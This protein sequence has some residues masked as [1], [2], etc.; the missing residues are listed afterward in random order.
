VSDKIPIDHH[1]LTHVLQ[2]INALMQRNQMI[3]MSATEAQQTPMDDIPVL[4]EVYEGEA[5]KLE[6]VNL[7]NFPTLN[8]LA[9]ELLAENQPLTEALAAR[10]L[11]EV[12]PLILK[13][14]KVAVLEES[15]KAEK[16]LTSKLEQEILTLLHQRLTTSLS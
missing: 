15:V 13:A 9:S 14:V 2:R 10:F 1:D 3:A 5:E 8:Q 11:D 16:L 6:A 12:Q 7:Q 4:T